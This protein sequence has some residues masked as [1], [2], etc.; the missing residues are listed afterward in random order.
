MREFN[1]QPV[2]LNIKWDFRYTG[3]IGSLTLD[4]VQ[5]VVYSMHNHYNTVS[6]RDEGAETIWDADSIV[7]ISNDNGYFG[8]YSCYEEGKTRLLYARDLQDFLVITPD[9]VN[10]EGE[11][12]NREC[13]NKLASWFDP[14]GAS[15]RPSNDII[16]EP[17]T[18]M[19]DIF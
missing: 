2:Y 15:S 12:I 6:T 5:G 1:F 17:D 14:E 11:L 10:S 9:D 8:F 13:I 7:I 4:E 3:D 19:P 16:D 18:D